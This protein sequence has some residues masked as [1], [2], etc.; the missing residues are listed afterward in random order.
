MEILQL[1]SEGL[2]GSASRM[3]APINEKCFRHAKGKIPSLINTLS[4]CQPTPETL[5][6]RGR[7]EATLLKEKPVSRESPKIPENGFSHSPLPIRREL[8]T[9]VNSVATSQP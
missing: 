6:G 5:A 7:R 9:E 1:A 2:H 8:L 3:T 4:I